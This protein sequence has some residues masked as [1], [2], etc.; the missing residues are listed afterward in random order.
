MPNDGVKTNKANR[1]AKRAITLLFL[2]VIPG[3]A[4]NWGG[5]SLGSLST[6]AEAQQ[7]QSMNND[8]LRSDCSFLKDPEEFTDMQARH[9]QDVSRTTEGVSGFMDLQAASLVDPANIPRKNL[10][11]F[12]L[13]DSMSK[14]GV[15]SAPI[16]T[17]SEYIRRVTLDLTGRIPTAD[18]VINFLN[19]KAVYKRDALVDKLIASPEFVDKWSQFFGDLYKNTAFST[20]INRY[21]SGREAFDQWIRNSIQTNKSYNQMAAELISASGDNYTNGA[22]NFIVGGNVPMG[23]AQD[24]MDGLAV[25]TATTFLG[26]GSMDC[27]LCHDGSGHLDAV[28][29]WGS[30]ITRAQAWGMSAFFARTGRRF[31]AAGTG[32]NYGT[33]TVTEAASGEYQLNT[34]SGNRQ[35]RAPINGKNTVDPKYLFGG[36]V[37]T[38]ENRRQGLAR[39][40]TADPQFSRAIVNYLWEEF[41][42]E[43]LVSPSSTF[44]LARLSA[45]VPQ[46][47]TPQ[48]ANPA[49]LDALSKDFSN[50][51]FNLRYII[52]LIA[53]SS[54]YQLSSQYAGEWKLEYVPLYARKYARRLDAEEVHDAVIMATGMPP[55]TT[56][57]E[58]GSTTNVTI[59]GYPIMG[60]NGLKLREVQWARQFPEPFEPRQRGDV[61]TFLNSFLRGDRDANARKYDSSILQSLNLMNNRFIT[62]R[63][64]MT[65]R[66]NTV[67][68]VSE[69]P[70]T[71]R[72]LL[73]DTTLTNDQIITQLYLTTLSRYPTDAEKA[74]ITPYFTSMGKQAAVENLQWVLLNKVDFIFNY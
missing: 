54:A 17:D 39:L 26:L 71:V 61:G 16:C 40:I 58:T 11:D 19:D 62:D 46:G 68:N 23:P 45:D 34:T 2:L 10:I 47:W 35:T 14:A 38:G 15:A 5:I 18:E 6:I 55:V 37:N 52:G 13:F 1:I 65:S 48:P 43:A 12:I 32:L 53:K 24:T 3:L 56:Y 22:V 33:Y 9:R 70:S 36:T 69:I 30:Q 31:Q 44:D 73:S 8:A 49:L 20:N 63:I 28:N 4:L 74:K 72:K 27:L 59:L 29:L 21:I 51:N 57:R 7:R 25:T 41:M 50:N 64:K 67:P 66:V 60:D 42:V